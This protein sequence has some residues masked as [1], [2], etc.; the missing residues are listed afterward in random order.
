M[1]DEA[2]ELQRGLTSRPSIPPN[3]GGT[4]EAE[5]AEYL[6]KW[7]AGHGLKDIT[8]VNA[9]D[10]RVAEGYRPNF[11]VS[12][13]GKDESRS[14]W[15]ISHLDIV[16][17]G[18]RSLWSHDP[19]E[20]YQEGDLLYGRGVEDNQ[21]GIVSS[22]LAL[23]AMKE[24]GIQPA[25]TLKLFMAADEESGSELGAKY[26]LGEHPELFGSKDEFIIPDHGSPDGMDIQIAEKSIYVLKFTTEGK[27]CHAS[28]PHSGTN[29]FVAASALVVE[30]NGLSD[31]F[32]RTQD[33]KF[34]PPFSTFVPSKKEPNVN[35]A[36]V[37]PGKD[38]F[39]MDCRVLPQL[40]FEEVAEQI[41]DI[42]GKI[43]RDYNVKIDWEIHTCK[44]SSV[45]SESAPVVRKLQEAVSKIKGGTT[46][47]V[48]IG[49]GTIAGDFRQTGRDAVVWS[50][51]L[52]TA[53]MPDEHCTIRD[54]LDDAKVFCAYALMNG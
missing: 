16:P 50:T 47:L 42:K 6:R 20:M 49:G 32:A 29:A 26:L 5:R 30:L 43:E 36:N 22:A 13:P 45:T 31:R 4:G 34:L 46:R 39:Y 14:L 54:L 18:D 21:H 33:E 10:D 48:G 27:Q 24:L 17:P 51:C 41:D 38:V 19:H 1:R 9:P 15:I 7:F 2:V 28:D 44:S 52:N 25:Y 8:E 11:I 53:H 23:L 40:D 37:L 35:A 3:M 12:L